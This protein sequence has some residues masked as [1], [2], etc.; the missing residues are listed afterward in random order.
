MDIIGS[1]PPC[2]QERKQAI[3]FFVF[4]SHVLGHRKPRESQDVLANSIWLPFMEQPQ[5]NKN[6]TLN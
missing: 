3:I 4:F 5:L 2:Y 1:G 6:N